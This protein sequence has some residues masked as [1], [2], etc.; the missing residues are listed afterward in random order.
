MLHVLNGDATRVKLERSGVPGEITVWADVLHDGPVPDV[1]EEQLRRKRAEHLVAK[2]GATPAH[3]DREFH[4]QND[5]YAFDQHD[6]VVFWFEHDLYDQLLLLRHLH[7][8]SQIDP[9]ST[10]FALICI[11][12]YLGELSPERLAELFPGRR[13]I[14]AEQ[15]RAGRE[16]WDRFR[17]PTP[18]GL[19]NWVEAGGA[20]PLQFMPAA[21]HRLFE[22]YPASRDGLSRTE[23]QALEVVRDGARTIGEAFVASQDMEESFFMGDLSFWD[24]IRRLAE[25]REPLLTA[26]LP[27]DDMPGGHEAVSLTDAG[28]RVLAAEAD[29]VVLNGIDRWIGGVHL[30]PENCWRFEPSLKLLQREMAGQ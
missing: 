4:R 2:F 15:I 13:P 16:G 12:E 17:A 10:R 26:T 18:S 3:V 21:L 11:G 22:E 24:V 9:G 29:H 27:P 23:R 5:L 6:E 30:T 20:D 28:R 8:L 25:G 7:W 1:P 19:L 14:T